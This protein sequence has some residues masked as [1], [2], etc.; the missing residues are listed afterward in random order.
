M[1][2]L[3]KQLVM[4]SGRTLYEEAKILRPGSALD[5]SRINIG[6]PAPPPQRVSVEDWERTMREIRGESISDTAKGGQ[7]TSR[8][9][10]LPL[11]EES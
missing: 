3:E 8:P 1:N 6:K 5:C 2:C 4:N 9:V 10:Q 7:D 11:P